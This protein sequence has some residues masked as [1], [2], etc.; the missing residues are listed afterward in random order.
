MK[1]KWYGHASFLITAE[2]G[3]TVITDPYTPETSGY[4]PIPD[5]PDVVITSSDNDSFHCRADLIAGTP[6]VID[7]LEV[8]QNGGQRTEKGVTF[9][10]IEAMEAL[11][12]RYHDPDQNGMYRFTVDG[13]SVGH[14]GDVGN[15]FSPAQLEFFKGVDV[16]L[17]LAGGHP[18]I[19]LSDLKTMIDAAQPRLVVP[20]HFRTLRYKPRNIFWIQNFLD[21]FDEQEIDFACD[22]QVTITP[23]KLPDKTRVLVLTHAC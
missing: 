2:D 1:L 11:N 17:A 20:M 23:D 5:A 13:V 4:L 19:E 18:T 16:L 21:L 12:H 15:A 8:A 22:Y 6:I 14:M 7:A 3:T 10:A 9:Q